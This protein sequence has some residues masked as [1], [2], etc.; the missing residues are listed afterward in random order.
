MGCQRHS[1]VALPLGKRP[2]THCV[3][4]WVDPGPV[5]I[6]VENLTPIGIRSPD[7]PAHSKLLYRLSYPGTQFFKIDITKIKFEFHHSVY[8]LIQ[9]VTF[10]CIHGVLDDHAVPVCE[11]LGQHIPRSLDRKKRIMGMASRITRLG[12]L[13]LLLVGGG[14]PS[15]KPGLI[16]KYTQSGISVACL[17]VTRV[18]ALDVCTNEHGRHVEYTL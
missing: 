10:T 11:W 13:G 9:S 18:A 16:S 8:V 2:G 17:A 6:S 4:G 15:E 5:W 1:L 3:E 7:H 12:L 14:G